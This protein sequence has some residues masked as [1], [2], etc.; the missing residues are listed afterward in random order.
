MNK[1]NQKGGAPNA[2]TAN[3][4]W[5]VV[6]SNDTDSAEI[7]LYG[8]VLDSLPR[9][10]WTNEVIEGQ[11]ITP[12]GF[13]DD[14]AAVRG[15]SEVVIKLNSCGG[16]VYTG[17]AIHNALKGLSG[18]KTV[19]VEGIAASAAS[20]IACAGD[21]VQ[22][23]PGS[24]MMIHGVSTMF[25]D[26]M[27]LADL[28]KAVKSVDAVERSLAAIYSTKTGI[29]EE[30]V[31]NMMANELWM[32]G[33]QAIEK[34]FADTM[35][36]DNGMTAS[37]SADKKMLLVAGV[38]HD[39]HAFHNI[40]GN[41]PVAI[42][43][44]DAEPVTA[45]NKNQNQELIQMTE[46]EL[47]AQYPELVAQIE[48]AAMDRARPEA[49]AAERKRIQEIESIEAQ[50]ADK[51]L[52]NAAKYGEHPQNAAQL[53][54]EAMK[55]N[56]QLGQNFLQ[57]LKSDADASGSAKV[58]SVPNGGNSD[59]GESEAVKVMTN[60]FKAFSAMKGGK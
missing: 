15:K 17:I 39:V 45:G 14:L 31:R 22:V 46:K 10:W 24:I 51:D 21:E 55:K 32:T 9:D 23:Y 33:A 60:A 29:E 41:I 58:E 44:S 20:V 19:I 57:N 2:A 16:D 52:I 50:I 30:A 40:P 13:M 34:G 48:N 49:A 7:T 38:R 8:D 35:L 5:N 11:Y 3:K 1:A 26:W 59:K 54:F 43:G 37:L 36:G 18:H 47:R 25:A 56:A 53:A 4:F 28:K 6:T 27:T 42:T 12:E